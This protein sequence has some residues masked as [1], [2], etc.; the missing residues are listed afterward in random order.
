LFFAYQKP[1]DAYLVLGG[2]PNREIFAA[3]LA[4]EHPDIKV[5]ISGGSQDPCI[6]LIFDKLKVAKDKVWMEDCSHNTFQNFYYSTPIL[7]KWG[8]QKVLLITDPPQDKRALPMARI[9]LGSHGIWVDLQIVPN[10][11]GEQSKYPLAVDVAVS[12][13]WAFA[14]QFYQPQC[15]HV[16]HLPEVDMKYWLERGFYCAPQAKVGH[17]QVLQ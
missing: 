4:K 9:I 17:Y 3:N 5:L 14:S 16:S 7:E 13:A 2:T 6:W 1:Y 15:M 11:G 10:S 12:L 8:V